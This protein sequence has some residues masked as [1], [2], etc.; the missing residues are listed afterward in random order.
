[1]LTILGCFTVCWLPY[2]VIAIYNRHCKRAK[3]GLYY[4]I[5]F[6]LAVANSGMNP[7]I[8]AWKNQNFRTA[9]LRLARCRSPNA[10]A[11]VTNHVPSARNSMMCVDRCASISD[12]LPEHDRRQTLFI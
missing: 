9:F 2:F 10:H 6:N 11:Y 4:E 8:Y 3:S 1:M 5:V 12:K 7:I